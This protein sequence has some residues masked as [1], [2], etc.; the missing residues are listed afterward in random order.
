MVSLPVRSFSVSIVN[1]NHVYPPA[2]VL[3]QGFTVFSGRLYECLYIIMHGCEDC[4]DI[5]ASFKCLSAVHLVLLH[6]YSTGVVPPHSTGMCQSEVSVLQPN[7]AYCHYYRGCSHLRQLFHRYHS[8]PRAIPSR[9]KSHALYFSCG[10]TVSGLTAVEPQ[11]RA[12]S[13]QALVACHFS[14]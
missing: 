11:D 4:R 3:L 14:F 8:R 9:H 2:C 6:K 1:V 12:G 5:H 10:T 13:K 7:L